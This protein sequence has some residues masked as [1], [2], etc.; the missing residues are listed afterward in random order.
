MRCFRHFG[1]INTRYST[2]KMIRLLYIIMPLIDSLNGIYV[3]RYEAGISIGQ[4]YRIFLV[5]LL[6]L[7]SVKLWEKKLF[8]ICFLLFFYLG[9]ST[10]VHIFVYN[11][12][13]LY[14]ELMQLSYWSL[15]PILLLCMY[16]LKKNDLLTNLDIIRILDDLCIITPLT[17]LIPYMM[18]WGYS[19][20][21]GGAGYKAFYDSTNGISFL[22]AVLTIYSTFNFMNKFSSK[23]LIALIMQLSSCLLVGT[24]ACY[25]SVIIAVLIGEYAIFRKSVRKGLLVVVT[26]LPLLLLAIIILGNSLS[27]NIIAII[28]R[29]LSFVDKFDSVTDFIT[30]GR[31]LLA[32]SAWNNMKL[33]HFTLNF[34]LG[35]GLPAREAEMDLFDVFFQYGIIGS[36]NYVFFIYAYFKRIRRIGQYNTFFVLTILFSFVYALIVGHVFT[37]AM[38]TMLF[39]LL[40][41]CHVP[42]ENISLER[43]Y[44]TC[45]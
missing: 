28:N 7:L 16:S 26:I 20:Y 40:L 14:K 8:S 29:K 31:T 36:A 41:C 11:N 32:V 39:V 15:F 12:L 1:G 37:N 22:L 45:T 13:S 35:Q 19:T 21:S 10:V 3:R 44:I 18:S 43:N 38:S 42:K 4:F 30:S 9:V 27:S 2:G 17:I 33:S 25:G 5:V 6:V 24:M 34:V 23:R